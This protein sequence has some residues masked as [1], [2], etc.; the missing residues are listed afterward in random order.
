MRYYYILFLTTLFI[1]CTMQP[2]E[3]YTELEDGKYYTEFFLTSKQ[4]EVESR[5]E[6]DDAA[7]VSGWGFIFAAGSSGELSENSLLLQRAPLTVGSS[8]EVT[9]IFEEYEGDCYL[10]IVANLRGEANSTVES[11]TIN[12]ATYSDFER[13]SVNIDSYYE[14]ASTLQ[15][16]FTQ[17]SSAIYIAS[18]ITQQTLDA[19]DKDIYMTHVGSKLEVSVAEG[20]DF[21]LI[22]TTLLNGANTAPLIGSALS[23]NLG[24]V[25]QYEPSVEPIYLLPNSGESGTNPTYLIIQGT[26]LKYGVEGYYKVA[27]SSIYADEPT[28]RTYDIRRNSFFHLSL[29]EIGSAGYK[30]FEDAVTSPANDVSYDITID[31]ENNRSEYLVSN[32]TYYAELIGSSVVAIGYGTEGV[33]ATIGLNLYPQSGFSS[34]TVYIEGSDGITITEGSV[35]AQSESES[36]NT[37]KFRATQSGAITIRCG[38]ILKEIPVSYTSLGIS[39][40]GGEVTTNSSTLSYTDCIVESGDSDILSSSGVVPANSSYSNRELIALLYPT[41]MSLGAIRLYLRQAS[42]FYLHN[43]TTNAEAESSQVIVYKSTGYIYSI[44]D[45][46]ANVNTAREYTIVGDASYSTSGSLSD[47]NSTFWNSAFSFSASNIGTNQTGSTFD[48]SRAMNF[49]QNTTITLT[50]IAGEEKSY[51]FDIKQYFEPYF[52]HNESNSYG[53]PCY[54]GC[55]DNYGSGNQGDKIHSCR[56]YNGVYNSSYSWEDNVSRVKDYL[57]IAATSENSY[58]WRFDATVSSSYIGWPYG[59]YDDTYIINITNLAGESFQKKIYF[60]ADHS[61]GDNGESTL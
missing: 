52:E 9:F 59:S 17:L 26:S 14:T 60:K 7:V 53:N 11:M 25:T 48:T 33:D 21:T 54:G 37:I 44:T 61:G 13:L 20:C 2:I 50:D 5:S 46:T 10:L 19:L 28:V 38:D 57:S 1:R 49:D 39:S 32:G 36:L 8:G 31:G 35:I 41:D 27:I 6:A 18:G 30:T 24:G 15:N 42:Q 22:S 34:P 55:I 51:S 56:V 40:S 12:E 4:V 3:P 29:T 23:A 58:T 47:F 16:G 43:A 45:G